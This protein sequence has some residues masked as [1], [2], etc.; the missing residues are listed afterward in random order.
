MPHPT[1]SEFIYGYRAGLQKAGQPVAINAGQVSYND[2][3]SYTSGTVGKEIS[4]LNTDVA[5]ALSA[6]NNLADEEYPVVSV[7]WEVGGISPSTGVPDSQTGKRRTEEYLAEADYHDVTAGQAE[8][9]VIRYSYDGNDYTYVDGTAVY[10]V[11]DPYVFDNDS[12]YYFRLSLHTPSKMDDVAITR[13]S[14]LIEDTKKISQIVSDVSDIENHIVINKTS[15]L[16]HSATLYKSYIAYSDGTETANNDSRISG[17]IPVNEGDVLAYTLKSIGTLC[18]VIAA[19]DSEKTYIKA[20]SVQCT[21]SNGSWITNTGTYTVPNGVSFIKF[22]TYKLSLSEDSLMKTVSSD[23]DDVV[24]ENAGGQWEG[25][26]WAGFG[27]SI[28]DIDYIDTHF[29]QPT[30]KYPPF[31]ADMSGMVFTNYGIA[32]GSITTDIQTKVKATTLTGFD[33]VT[34]EGSVNDHATSKAI[35]EVGDT[36]TD[37]FAGAIYQIANYVYTNSNATLIFITDYVGRYV[38]INPAPDGSDFYGDCAPTKAN[39][40]DLLQ[41]DYI[42]MM[43]KQCKYFGIPCITAGQD[44]GIN[45]M[46]ADLYLMDHI[47]SS[48]V[49]GKQY[50]QTIWSTLKNIKPR[51][52][53]I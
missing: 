14:K 34:V 30:G 26:K 29:L 40:L 44:C 4:E 16:Y 2:E 24:S 51:V 12:G 22:S 25:K 9:Y 17:F 52:L 47:H 8:L 21:G 15:D 7:A 41:I 48:Y 11:N 23:I 53:S 45:L 42:E 37:T 33:I 50:A 5:N 39:T 3:A 43:I 20:K 38:H 10:G 49:G 13:N 31:L 35:G 1:D 28:T 27:T 6:I 46:T 32:G 36:G 18:P 19:Y